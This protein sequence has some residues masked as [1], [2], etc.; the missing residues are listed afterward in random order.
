MDSCKVKFAQIMHIVN[1]NLR[2]K[3]K[4]MN[5]T[6]NVEHVSVSKFM[7]TIAIYKWRNLHEKRDLAEIAWLHAKLNED[8]RTQWKVEI[9]D[10]TGAE[11]S[12]CL[13]TPPT[14]HFKPH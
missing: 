6:D 4:M 3:G 5:L 8:E 2:Q 13:I 1:V 14:L 12:V 10:S 9:E 11:A 7:W